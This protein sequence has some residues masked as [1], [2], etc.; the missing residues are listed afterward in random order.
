MDW[1]TDI[2]PIQGP[3]GQSSIQITYQNRS[4]RLDIAPDGPDPETTDDVMLVRPRKSRILFRRKLFDYPISLSPDTL[5][6]LGA[7]STARIG[8][9][10]LR[11]RAFPIAPE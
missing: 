6:K 11:G 9:S 10:Y 8:L 2:L 3:A 5:I 4:R 1:W 7:R